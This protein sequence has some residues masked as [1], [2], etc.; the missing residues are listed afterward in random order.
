MMK[1]HASLMGKGI[2]RYFGPIH[3][4]VIASIDLSVVSKI[5]QGLCYHLHLPWDI[6]DGIIPDEAKIEV[7]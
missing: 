5:T 4:D 1:M 7:A 6:K 2:A 3:F